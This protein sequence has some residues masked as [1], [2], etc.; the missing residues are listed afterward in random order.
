MMI[1]MPWLGTFIQKSRLWFCHG[2]VLGAVVACWPSMFQHIW[3]MPPWPWCDTGGRHAMVMPELRARRCRGM[4]CR[5]THTPHVSWLQQT[6][7]AD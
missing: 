2:I 4:L 6:Q 1:C 5:R 7:L 3:H